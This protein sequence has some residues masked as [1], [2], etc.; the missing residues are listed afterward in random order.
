MK[1]HLKSVNKTNLFEFIVFMSQFRVFVCQLLYAMLELLFVLGALLPLELVHH[2]TVVALCQH[3]WIECEQG[4]TKMYLLLIN[5]H[6]DDSLPLAQCND[7]NAGTHVLRIDTHGAFVR[8]TR[9]LCLELVNLVT[10]LLV[11]TLHLGRVLLCPLAVSL[12]VLE[13]LAVVPLR[14]LLGQRHP[15]DL[16]NQRQQTRVGEVGTVEPNER[17]LVRDDVA[18][19]HL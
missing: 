3:K 10:K 17:S 2:S 8:P 18:K 9:K 5:R 16:D 4:E 7:C 1:K 15:L 6:L 12:N 11:V 14:L 19:R 13:L